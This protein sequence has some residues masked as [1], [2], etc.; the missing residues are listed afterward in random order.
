MWTG[1]PWSLLEELDRESRRRRPQVGEAGDVNPLGLEAGQDRASAV[2]R[3]HDQRLARADLR[4]EVAGELPRSN[5]GIGRPCRSP[6]SRA[7]PGGK[8]AAI[9]VASSISPHGM[10]ASQPAARAWTIT[11]VARS[12]STTTTAPQ[13]PRRNQRTYRKDRRPLGRIH[14]QEL[15]ERQ[16]RGSAVAKTQMRKAETRKCS[17]SSSPALLPSSSGSTASG[18]YRY[19]ARLLEHRHFRLAGRLHDNC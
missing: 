2:G 11:V 8:P 18:R 14:G 10:T 9:A 19:L 12:T 17:I 1:W 7:V 4:R 6:A 16:S 5:P 3:G 13:T 15:P